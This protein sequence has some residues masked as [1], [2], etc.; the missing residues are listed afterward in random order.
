[1]GLLYLR[2]HVRRLVTNVNDYVALHGNRLSIRSLR[3]GVNDDVV[4]GHLLRLLHGVDTV[5]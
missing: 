2:A 5:L 4:H 3:L 1:M